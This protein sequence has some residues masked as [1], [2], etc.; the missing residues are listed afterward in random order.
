MSLSRYTFN[1]YGNYSVTENYPAQLLFSL[2]TILSSV[3]WRQTWICNSHPISHSNHQ[4]QDT[5]GTNSAVTHSAQLLSVFYVGISLEN[6]SQNKS[7]ELNMW[8][9]IQSQCARKSHMC[10]KPEGFCTTL[11]YYHIQHRKA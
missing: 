11:T 6:K 9:Q 7:I 1:I 8:K 10:F 3:T 2:T 5:W 4:S